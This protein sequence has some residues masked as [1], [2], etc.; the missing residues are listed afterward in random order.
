MLNTTVFSD[1]RVNTSD[2]A[3]VSDS[4]DG[5]GAMLFVTIT[6]CVYALS[7]LAFILGNQKKTKGD[8]H[9]KEIS[10]YIKSSKRI[11]RDAA[12]DYVLK[13]RAMLLANSVIT[14]NNGLGSHRSNSR[15]MMDDNQE[16]ETVID[17]ST[18]E[19]IRGETGSSAEQIQTKG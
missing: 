13:F 12:K 9:D 17:Y 7:I 8:D 3:T 15:P 2:F 16:S 4:Y 5:Y 6:I 18:E 14:N 10:N 19:G 1:T 11:E